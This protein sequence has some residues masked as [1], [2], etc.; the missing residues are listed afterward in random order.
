[1]TCPWLPS[2]CQLRKIP[3][4]SHP[5]GIMRA[6]RLQRVVVRWCRTVGAGNPRDRHGDPVCALGGAGDSPSAGGDSLELAL[7][8]S[9]WA[10]CYYNRAVRLRPFG[11][12]LS[13]K[14]RIAQVGFLLAALLPNDG[15]L[16]DRR[17][18]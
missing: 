15:V 5:R 17:S 8:P 4:E 1:M 16:R 7:P 3:D 2:N 14:D 9:A 10:G 11:L 18:G 12:S 13:D 6:G